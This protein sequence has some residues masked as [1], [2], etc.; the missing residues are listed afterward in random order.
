ME[1][2]LELFH[3]QGFENTTMRDIALKAEVATGAAYYY[4]PS[5]EAIIMDFYRRA[6]LEMQ[7][8]IEAALKPVKQM[9]SPSFGSRG[10][11]VGEI[12]AKP[13]SVIQNSPDS[14]IGFV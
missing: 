10:I 2:S 5:K 7:P 14:F 1:A 11:W 4:Y 3:R 6:S 12:V 9:A 8:K 13:T